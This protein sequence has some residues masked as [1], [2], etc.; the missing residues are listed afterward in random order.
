MDEEGAYKNVGLIERIARC[1]DW[2][3]TDAPE[4]GNDVDVQCDLFEYGL[5]TELVPLSEIPEAVL[6]IRDR[7]F[8]EFS[9]EFVQR[10]LRAA[11]KAESSTR[12]K[13]NPN[14]P[15]LGSR[16][17]LIAARVLTDTL[18]LGA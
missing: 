7:F 4:W 12:H 11:R 3:R 18:P 10:L 13:A 1:S 8:P 9:L 15:T 5:F 17:E 14:L 16:N 6:D 2:I